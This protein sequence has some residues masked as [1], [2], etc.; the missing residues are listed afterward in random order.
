MNPAPR[1]SLSKAFPKSARLLKR[2]EFFMRPCE[3][4]Q[5]EH[6]RFFFTRQGQG[7]MGVSLAKKVL[8]EAVARNRIRRLLR[9]VFREQRHRLGGVDV[10]IVGRDELKTDWSQM[11]KA[12]VE[13]EFQA[14]EAARQH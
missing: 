12:A 13:K 14:W 3:R 8:R 4:F 2:R 9:E 1:T 7:R 6:F 11:G 10:H 5:T